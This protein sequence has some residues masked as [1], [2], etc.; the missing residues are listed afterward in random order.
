MPNADG[1][2]SGPVGH[3]VEEFAPA[4]RSFTT[5]PAVGFLGVAT[6]EWFDMV[7]MTEFA[8]ASQR[9]GDSEGSMLTRAG[10]VLLYGMLDAQ[11]ALNA[12]AH[13]YSGHAEFSQS[14][15]LF[16]TETAL[17]IDTDG[18]VILEDS[19]EN[20]KKRVIG[21][22]KV[23]SRRVVGADLTVSLGDKMGKALLQYKEL[24]DAVMHPRVGARLPRVGKAE[25]R[26]AVEAVREYFKRLA[27]ASPYLFRFYDPLLRL[28]G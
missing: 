13:V 3:R 26:G 5:M 27:S 8:F 24:R 22:P 19:Y 17:G 6:R 10:L 4:D 21:I 9:E 2:F 1:T 20:F 18:T 23:L 12:Q 7:L 16:L 14:E 28:R 15:I 11:L 25:L